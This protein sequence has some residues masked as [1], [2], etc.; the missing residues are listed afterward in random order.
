M[1][2]ADHLI[3]LIDQLS[4]SDRQELLRYLLEKEEDT[5]FLRMV[6]Q[7]IGSDWDDPQDNAGSKVSGVSASKED[8]HQLIDQIQDPVDL[9]YAH[10]MMRALAEHDDQSWYW[11]ER[12]QKG[13]R[14]DSEDIASGR[15][16]E[17]FET[18][19]AVMRRLD[20]LVNQSHED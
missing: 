6:E 9:A 1:S 10:V 3:H 18:S 12:W 4:E 19:D 2:I 15:I 14:E 20:H 16:S 13:E 11:T 5:D 7:S 17:P 8:I